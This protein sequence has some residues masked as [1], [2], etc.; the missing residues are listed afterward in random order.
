MPDFTWH[1]LSFLPIKMSNAVLQNTQSWEQ[2]MQLHWRRAST[3]RRSSAII[4]MAR[5]IFGVSTVCI[6][7]APYYTLVLLVC[8]KN[9]NVNLSDFY[10]FETEKG[11]K[12]N[13]WLMEKTVGPT[14]HKTNSFP[15]RRTPTAV[16][17]GTND[18]GG[19]ERRRV[20]TTTRRTKNIPT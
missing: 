13:R 8:T 6:F 1:Y 7:G 14:E 2:K 12:H 20:S 16:L 9:R 5:T 19:D 17:S 15:I 10:I 11:F 4:F 3:Q 18:I